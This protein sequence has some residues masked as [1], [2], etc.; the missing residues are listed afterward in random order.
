MKSLVALLLLWPLSKLLPHG[1]DTPLSLLAA[2][3]A[4]Y[5][6]CKICSQL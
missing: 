4:I 6:L 3:L 5:I 1:F 2:G